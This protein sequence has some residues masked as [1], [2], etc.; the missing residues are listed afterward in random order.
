MTARTFLGLTP[1]TPVVSGELP[2]AVKETVSF[3]GQSLDAETRA[4]MEARFGQDFSRIRVHDDAAAGVSAKAVEAQAY[5]MGEH[6]VFGAGRYSPSSSSGRELIAHE[7]AHAIQQYKGHAGNRGAAEREAEEA[8]EAIRAGKPAH[9]VGQS[10][11]EPFQRQPAGPPNSPQ[12]PPPRQQQT[13]PPA[14]KNPAAQTPAAQRPATQGPATQTPTTQAPTTQ[15]PQTANPPQQQA[16]PPGPVDRIRKIVHDSLSIKEGRVSNYTYEAALQGLRTDFGSGAVIHFGDAFLQLPRNEQ[17]NKLTQELGKIDKWS[18]DNGKLVAA[19]LGD[20]DVADRIRGLSATNLAAL[21][22]KVADTTVKQYAD[23]LRTMST[24]LEMGLTRQGQG[25]AT[26]SIGNVI[27]VVEPDQPNGAHAPAG[28]G[29]TFIEVPAADWR[30]LTDTDGKT[31]TRFDGFPKTTITIRTDYA[32]GVDPNAP[33]AYGRGTTT[34]DQ[35]V[36][37]TTVRFHEGSHGLDFLKFIKDH[38]YPEFTGHVGMT[39]PEFEAAVRQYDAARTQFSHQAREFTESR[40]HCV[41]ITIDQ[42]N[43]QQRIQSPA[44]CGANP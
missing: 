32:R 13:P 15:A 2:T 19:D 31:I 18:V 12:N 26:A 1:A 33:S 42:F 28:R 38:P 37:A 22:D 4:F 25:N 35:N 36:G 44:V 7:L 17:L 16:P 20:R 21:R 3:G 39:L 14:G 30:P 34:R 24:P 6:I 29:E 40:T 43:R 27:V 10:G 8:A 9:V 23:S 5:T 11:P 41:G